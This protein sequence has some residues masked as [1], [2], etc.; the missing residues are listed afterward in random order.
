MPA[1]LKFPVDFKADTEYTDAAL[2]EFRQLYGYHD[3]IQFGDLDA[4]T[5][6]AVLRRAQV[7]K[8][9]ARP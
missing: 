2:A 8:K 7:L 6:R 5:Q 9:E 4:F 3:S 1:E